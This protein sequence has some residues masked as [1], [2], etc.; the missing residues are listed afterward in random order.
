M[1]KLQGVDFLVVEDAPLSSAVGPKVQ[2]FK[3][4]L[5]TA[6]GGQQQRIRPKTETIDR[7]TKLVRCTGELRGRWVQCT[8]MVPNVR[9]LLSRPQ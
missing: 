5:C 2:N 3:E 7:G 6:R 1:V 4:P 9:G 8:G